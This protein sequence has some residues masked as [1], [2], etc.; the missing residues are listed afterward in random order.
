MKHNLLPRRVH[1]HGTHGFVSVEDVLDISIG[2]SH[3]VTDVVYVDA[4]IG[5]AGSCQK[6]KKKDEQIFEITRTEKK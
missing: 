4:F 3:E 1:G 2:D 5:Y 6:Q